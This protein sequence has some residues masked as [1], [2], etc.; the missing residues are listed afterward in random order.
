[1]VAKSDRTR[2]AVVSASSGWS[3]EVLSWT[4]LTWGVW[5][6]SLSAIDDQDLLVG[7]LCGL[8]CGVVAAATRRAIGA[9][10]HPRL[11]AVAPTAW[12]PL[13]IVV[14]TA[15]VLVAAWR[16]ALRGPQIVEVDIGAQGDAPEAAARRAIATAVV[17]ATPA[18]VVLDVDPGN[19]RMLVHSLRSPG[20]SLHERYARR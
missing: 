1:M 15:A 14:D 16:P 12:L 4:L 19:G 3:I 13:A 7:G 17:S 11:P 6:L 8:G 10:W 5:L 9:R 20:P 18:T 2:R